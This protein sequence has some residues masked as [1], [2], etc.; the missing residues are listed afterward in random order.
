MPRLN[1]RR[2]WRRRQATISSS[3]SAFV[4]AVDLHVGG[5]LLMIAD[6]RLHP[7]LPQVPLI[8]AATIVIALLQLSLLKRLNRRT[9]LTPIAVSSA[10]LICVETAVI[11]AIGHDFLA[12]TSL[13]L[14]LLTMF[15]ATMLPW[16]WRAQLV[17]VACG[18]VSFLWNAYMLDVGFRVAGYTGVIVAV[19]FGTSV[20]IAYEFNRYRTDLEQRNRAIGRSQ[21][22]IEAANHAL[23]QSSRRYAGLVES[24]D[25]TV[26][27]ADAE[28]FRFTFV[29]QQAHGL[30]GYPSERWLA[31]EHFWVEHLHPSDRDQ[32]IADRRRATA[33]HAALECDYRMI[34]ADGRIVWIRDSA[35]VVLGDDQPIILRGMFLDITERRRVD[36]A[37]RHSEQYFRS[38]LENTADLIS[39]MNRDGSARYHSPSYERLLGYATDEPF[40]TTPF[41]FVHPDDRPRIT[42]S[43]WRVAQHPRHRV[44]RASACAAST[45]RWPSKTGE[46][47]LEDPAVAGIV[48]ACRDITARKEAEVATCNALRRPLRPRARRRSWRT[49]PRAS[50]S[51]T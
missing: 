37:L 48:V 3:T 21:A 1:Q 45:T 9:W 42:E 26:W 28:T 29:S 27:E 43:F 49:A 31:E 16:R 30:L 11:G 14:V 22:A 34:A 18:T 13:V 19:A 50:S 15:T 39:I 24:L 35:T 46:V 5:R 41:H 20:Y 17:A 47:L 10:G 25:G 23:Q 2:R 7:D 8:R 32:A 36:A 40:A 44:L 6:V 4:R 12:N 51:P 33:S 38:L